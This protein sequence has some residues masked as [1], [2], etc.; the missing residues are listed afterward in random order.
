MTG[1]AA[2]APFRQRLIANE[3]MV[4]VFVKTPAPQ[5]IEILGAAGFDFVVIDA[6][7]ADHAFV[8]DQPLAKGRARREASHGACPRRGFAA[9]VRAITPRIRR[10]WA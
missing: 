10:A 3:R 8:G 7:H 2:R 4:G 6:E 9:C 1:F 5:V